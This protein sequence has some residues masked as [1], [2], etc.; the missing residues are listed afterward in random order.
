MEKQT[1]NNCVLYN[2][3]YSRLSLQPHSENYYGIAMG[4]IDYGDTCMISDEPGLSE[5]VSPND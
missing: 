4:A 3:N 2:P 1:P 5:E